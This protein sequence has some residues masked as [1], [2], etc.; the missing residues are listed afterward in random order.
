MNQ[1]PLKEISKEVLELVK[2]TDATELGPAMTKTRKVAE[3]LCLA[4]QAMEEW[5]KSEELLYGERK[6]SK[7]MSGAHACM[8]RG[9]NLS[10]L[11]A[12]VCI[13]TRSA[14]PPHGLA[15]RP[16]PCRNA[17]AAAV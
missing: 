7:C 4:S 5:N 1:R 14:I 16:I 8:L 12:H 17:A 10:Q 3:P 9:R 15:R 2:T 13:V 6:D 11:H